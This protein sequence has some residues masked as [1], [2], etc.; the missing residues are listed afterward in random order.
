MINEEILISYQ[1][2]TKI[3]S[4]RVNG[5]RFESKQID[6]KNPRWVVILAS[7]HYKDAYR[8]RIGEFTAKTAIEAVGKGLK[9]ASKYKLKNECKGL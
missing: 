4:Y 9:I 3:I 6:P 7:S 5:K 8:N 2:R 1:P